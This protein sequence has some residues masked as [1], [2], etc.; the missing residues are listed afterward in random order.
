MFVCR[1]N[2]AGGGGTG[3][4]GGS[5]F[6]TLAA[7]LFIVFCVLHFYLVLS[8]NTGCLHAASLSGFC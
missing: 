6:V 1:W 8:I 2:W 4:T 7:V 3:G 5:N